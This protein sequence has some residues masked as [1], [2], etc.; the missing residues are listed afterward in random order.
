MFN[1]GGVTTVKMYELT[2]SFLPLKILM[3]SL[4]KMVSMKPSAL[5][6]ERRGEVFKSAFMSLMELK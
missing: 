4:L 6:E 2:W 3:S 1:F 5:G